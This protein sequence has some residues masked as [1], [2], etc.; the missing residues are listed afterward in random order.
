[1]LQSSRF[2]CS[3]RLI[4]VNENNVEA[5][6]LNEAVG[7]LVYSPLNNLGSTFR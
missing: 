6:K 2:T 1:M 4:K 5:R 7:F 3:R